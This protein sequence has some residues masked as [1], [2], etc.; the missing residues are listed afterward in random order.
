MR[1]IPE[2]DEDV[3]NNT[4]NLWH[5]FS[6]PARKPEGKSGAAGCKLFLDHGRKIICSGNE[7]HFDY[8][9]KREAFIAQRRT[10]SEIAVALH[11]IEEGTGKGFWCRTLNRLYGVHAMQLQKPEHVIGKHN[12]HIEILLRL[13]ADEALFVGDPRHRNAL[14]GLITEPTNTIEPKNIDAYNAKNYVNIDILSNSEHFIPVSGT[15]RRFMVPT[16]SQERKSDHEYFRK[17][18]AQLNDGGYEALLWH[19]LHEIDIRD[20][21]VRAVPKTA[22]LAE[23][24]AYS[25]K[26]IE[27]LVEKACNEG[28]VPCAHPEHPELSY[29]TEPG[30]YARIGFDDFIGRHS[31]RELAYMGPLTVKRRLVKEWGCMTGKS[32]RKQSNGVRVHGTMWPP[33][34]ELREKFEKK[35]GPQEWLYPRITK[36]RKGEEE[37]TETTPDATAAAAQ[38]REKSAAVEKGEIGEGAFEVVGRAPAGS[39]CHFCGKGRKVRLVHQQG[40]CGAVQA[41][42]ACAEKAWGT[43][44][45]LVTNTDEEGELA[46][47]LNR[48]V[49]D[50]L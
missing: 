28:C 32:V 45:P 3:V 16:V 35:F 36:W 27:L 8:I 29:N 20:F 33:L 11:T 44:Q 18:L 46:E 34:P 1:F 14:F 13:T 31:N 38:K 9:M 4:L 48:K 37:P 24:A 49:A 40:G 22:A 39:Q 2:R 47:Q 5:G 26:G 15:A 6:I 41:H 10:L 21:N 25:R 30:P 12:K 43:P 23:Q 7:E 19:L 17:I 50:L 42:L